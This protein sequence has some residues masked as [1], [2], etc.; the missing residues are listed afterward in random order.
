MPN[1]EKMKELNEEKD[2]IEE[3]EEEE[4][5]TAGE[6]EGEEEETKSNGQLLYEVMKKRGLVDD[7]DFEDLTH[8]LRTK[9][10]TMA[11][12][13]DVADLRGSMIEE[14]G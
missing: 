14:L 12:D 3:L 13:L 4:L 9:W 2:K 8:A 7:G 5:D 6:E 10:D 11:E 1:E